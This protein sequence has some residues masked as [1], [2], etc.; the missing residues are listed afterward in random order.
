MG[1]DDI[2]IGTIHTGKGEE[3]DIPDEVQIDD[4][5]RVSVPQTERRKGLLACMTCTKPVCDGCQGTIGIED[6]AALGGAIAGTVARETVRL[7][8]AWGEAFMREFR[9]ER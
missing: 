2:T 6:L 1:D 8:T 3:N 7:A 5:D 4:G 9:A